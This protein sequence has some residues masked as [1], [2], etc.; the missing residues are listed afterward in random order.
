VNNKVE[1]KINFIKF[2]FFA[3]AKK[4]TNNIKKELNKNEI[5]VWIATIKKI[6]IKKYFLI[7]VPLLKLLFRELIK[8][9]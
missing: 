9:M 3:N 8:S 5:L 4:N 2:I 7:N 1:I 6:F